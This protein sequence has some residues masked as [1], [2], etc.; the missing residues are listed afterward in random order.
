MSF[1]SFGPAHYKIM[2]G[3]DMLSNLKLVSATSCGVALCLGRRARNVFLVEI[4]SP[5]ISLE[6]FSFNSNLLR[7]PPIGEHRPEKDP[8]A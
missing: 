1:R 7:L 8:E 6:S 4:L 3:K 2:I 5:S